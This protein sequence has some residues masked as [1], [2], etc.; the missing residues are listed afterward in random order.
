VLLYG[1]MLLGA[2]VMT[3][4]YQSPVVGAL[5][6]IMSMAIIGVHGMLSGTASMDFGGR[7]NTGIAVGIIDGFVYLGTAVMSFSYAI[8]LPQE[9]L[10]KVRDAAGNVMLDDR[11]RELTELVGPAT[12]PDN[13][14]AWPISMIA[15]AAIGLYL[16]TRVWHASP[17]RMRKKQ[18]SGD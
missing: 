6:I 2:V 17:E 11:G 18:E 13:W 3:F 7:K 16:A 4:A 12:D 8:I 1:L 14:L 15:V 5:V 10:E 9:K